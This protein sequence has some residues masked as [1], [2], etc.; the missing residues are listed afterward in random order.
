MYKVEYV[1]VR[2]VESTEKEKEGKAK[3]GNK[4]RQQNQQLSKIKA[5]HYVQYKPVQCGVAP[6]SQHGF[7]SVT[8]V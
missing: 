4:G 3:L 8:W 6:D 7:F 2:T 1:R 5:Y